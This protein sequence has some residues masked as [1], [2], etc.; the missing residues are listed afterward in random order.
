[1]A[2][3]SS[4]RIHMSL[5]L[6][7]LHMTL[8]P[9]QLTNLGFKLRGGGTMVTS[10][11]GKPF[12]RRSEG[13]LLRKSVSSRNARN[14]RSTHL[15]AMNGARPLRA[16]PPPIRRMDDAAVLTLFSDAESEIEAAM[17]PSNGVLDAS[18]GMS[19]LGPSSASSPGAG[20]AAA[21]GLVVGGTKVAMG[22]GRVVAVVGGGAGV[23]VAEGVDLVG[24]TG[25]VAP[26]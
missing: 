15:S 1:M 6:S 20:V 2:S 22:V 13:S 16:D 21:E 12:W 4:E 14:H 9:F 19:Y 23:G 5:K 11:W 18:Y 7:R 3:N 26:D 25:V 17:A 10:A 24:G 8:A